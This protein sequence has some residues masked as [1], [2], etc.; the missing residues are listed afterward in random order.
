MGVFGQLSQ[1]ILI[2]CRQ[3]HST[4]SRPLQSRDHMSAWQL[5]RYGSSSE[6]S[7]CDDVKI[8]TIR[9]PD[10]VLVRVHAAS[11]NPVDVAMVG[12]YSSIH[13]SRIL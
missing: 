11:V 5:H 12:L 1:R 6:L 8:P 2:G 13:Y 3:L 10:E 9:R 7:L 4:E